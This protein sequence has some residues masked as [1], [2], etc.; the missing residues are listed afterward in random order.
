MGLRERSLKFHIFGILSSLFSSLVRW[1]LWFER[2]TVPEVPV[3][4]A[5]RWWWGWWWL[6]LPCPCYMCTTYKST[7]AP[8]SQWEDAD[9]PLLLKVSRHIHFYSIFWKVSTIQIT[10][11]RYFLA[12]VSFYTVA[13]VFLVQQSVPNKRGRRVIEVKKKNSCNNSTPVLLT[14][15][16][17][18]LSKAPTLQRSEES[19]LWITYQKSIGIYC[20]FG[21]A[22]HKATITD[23]SYQ[24]PDP[25]PSSVSKYGSRNK[26]CCRRQIFFK[27]SPQ[28]HTNNSSDWQFSPPGPTVPPFH[29]GLILRKQFYRFLTDH[30]RQIN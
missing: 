26:T 4:A 29:T 28:F 19:Y 18:F 6:C 23:K 25:C 8:C 7:R 15:L 14:C 2:Y 11:Q 21:A 22:A 10:S 9:D 1:V 12:C 30:E 24:I 16:N 3:P 17:L 5:G 13:S 27:L 20:C